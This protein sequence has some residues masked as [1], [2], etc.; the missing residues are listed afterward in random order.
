MHLMGYL[1]TGNFG[2]CKLWGFLSKK[3]PEYEKSW[4]SYFRDD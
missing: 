2:Q 1:M 3:V 4:R